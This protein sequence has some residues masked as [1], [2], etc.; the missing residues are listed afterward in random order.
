MAAAQSNRPMSAE[1]IFIII[2]I[3]AVA[4]AFVFLVV[5]GVRNLSRGKH[6]MF[7]V[8]AIVI[9]FIVFAICAAITAGAWAKA[10]ILTVMIM[11]LLAI[12]GLI[13]SGLRGLTG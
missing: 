3:V 6:S 13:M 2:A 11:S 5:F 4:V 1:F 10:A 12:L 9:P 8:G 7:T